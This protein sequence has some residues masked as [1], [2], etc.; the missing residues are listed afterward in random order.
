MWRIAKMFNL[1]LKK[2][3][4]V[5]VIDRI[6]AVVVLGIVVSFLTYAVIMSLT[7]GF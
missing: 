3:N 7:V 4:E 2:W 5:S 6:G 1:R